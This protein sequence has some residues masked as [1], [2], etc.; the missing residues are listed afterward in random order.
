M[1]IRAERIHPGRAESKI[2]GVW[3]DREA[4]NSDEGQA[5]ESQARTLHD[6]GHAPQCTEICVPSKGPTARRFLLNMKLQ[7]GRRRLGYDMVLRAVMALTRNIRDAEKAYALACF[8]VLAH[9]RDDHVK[10]FSFLLNANNE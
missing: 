4:N 8:N 1:L 7:R 10:N 9:N 3:L 2:R 5:Q 6:G